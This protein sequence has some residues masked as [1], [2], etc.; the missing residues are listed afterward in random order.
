MI[1]INEDFAQHRAKQHSPAQERTQL[2]ELLDEQRTCDEQDYQQCRA[3][4]ADRRCPQLLTPAQGCAT[5]A[6]HRV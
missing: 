6:I 4:G 5:V 2:C 3:R 1:F